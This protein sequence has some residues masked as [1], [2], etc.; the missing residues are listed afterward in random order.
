MYDRIKVTITREA[1]PE[2]IRMFAESADRLSKDKD[3]V[4]PVVRSE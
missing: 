1:N 2:V 4:H 3:Y